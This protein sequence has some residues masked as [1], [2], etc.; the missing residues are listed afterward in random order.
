MV[1]TDVVV[2]GG[3]AAGF[4]AAFRASQ[5]G[6]KVIL[7]EKERVG[8]ICPNWG[9]IP[10]SFMSHCIEVLKSVKEAGEDGI[11]VDNVHIDY[12]KLM[13]EKEKRINGVV[14]GMEAVLQDTGVQVLI[15]SAKLISPSEIEIELEDGKKALIQANKIVI[16]SG[17]LARRYDIPGA[18]GS[19]V[20]TAKELLSLD[21][22]PHS[23]AIIGRSVTAMELTAVWSHLGCSVHLIARK[24]QLLPDEDEELVKVMRQ[25]MED[26]GLKIFAG[27]EIE[28]I[29]EDSGGKTVTI[30]SD[31]VKQ[32]I[33]AQF[34]VFALGQQPYID[35]LG[36]E[37]AGIAVVED[38]IVT[39]E[40]METGV[41]GIYAV[42]DVTGENMMASVAM[43][44]GR[45]AGENAAGVGVTMDYRVVPHAIRTMPPMA[46]VGITE[47]EAVKR[48]MD[49]K[50]GRFPFEQNPKAG[51]M[52]ESRGFVKI[53]VDSA[54]GEVLGVHILGPQATELIHEAAIVMKMRGTFLDIAGMIHGHPCLHE[55][56]QMAA[57]SLFG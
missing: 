15:G 29:D 12:T 14:A 57:K 4:V 34:V 19:G 22:L 20:L 55:A 11:I 2:I 51:I 48:G 8:G 23:L 16:A 53:V 7:V 50:V 18:Y 27:V 36:L 49:I 5:L 24:P 56:V 6:S 21:E 33:K 46:A 38:R 9:C 54:S 30:S 10:M 43:M 3:G 42:G 40:R 25:A 37:N 17:S 35:G 26:D 39:N 44:Q 31:G 13:G 47:K 1:K 28:S 41:K 45:I 52:R 32:K